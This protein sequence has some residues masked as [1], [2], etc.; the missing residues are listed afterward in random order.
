MEP[1]S[2]SFHE[3]FLEVQVKSHTFILTAIYASPKFRVRKYYWDRMSNLSNY[4]ALPWLI[5][6]DFND[7]MNPNEN[8]GGRHPSKAKLE[9]FL[10]F[11]NAASLIDLG[12]PVQDSHGQMV[13][14]HKPL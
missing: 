13:E 9:H 11:L 5:M 2:S 12:L 3:L 4:I 14:I 10:N 8:F 1:I 6:S 7:I